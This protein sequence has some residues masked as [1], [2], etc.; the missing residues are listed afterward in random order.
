MNHDTHCPC[1]V[2]LDDC[3]S[4]L[5]P[6]DMLDEVET[7]YHDLNAAYEESAE[8]RSRCGEALIED[9]QDMVEHE[10]VLLEARAAR[11]WAIWPAVLPGAWERM[12]EWSR[13]S[14][15]SMV[16]LETEGKQ[17]A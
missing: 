6:A 10:L 3:L 14:K 4:Y 9:L 17:D 15:G 8:H 13:G 1:N 7:L 5:R 11:V 16:Q 2:V 12:A